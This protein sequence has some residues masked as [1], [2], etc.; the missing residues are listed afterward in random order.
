MAIVDLMGVRLVTV[1]PDDSV[2]R[3]VERMLDE[4]IGSVAVCEGPRLVGMLTE[5]DVLRLAGRGAQLDELRVRQ[6]MT[7]RLVTVGPADDVLEAAR[8]M[9]AHRIRHVPVVHGEHVLGMVA[10]RDVLDALVDRLYLTHDESVRESVH[11]LL[12]RKAPAPA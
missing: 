7:T 4:G 1:E 2:E 3:A 5:R 10:M 6:V 11:E 9:T 12:R 8:L